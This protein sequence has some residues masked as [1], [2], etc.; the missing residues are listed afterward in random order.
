MMLAEPDGLTASHLTKHAGCV[1]PPVSYPGMPLPVQWWTHVRCW[2]QWPTRAWTP[3][4][5]TVRDKGCLSALACHGPRRL[6]PAGYVQG[7]RA[8]PMPAQGRPARFAFSA[9]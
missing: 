4:P 9:V 8:D 3:P 7:I 2:P 1:P 6:P 5:R